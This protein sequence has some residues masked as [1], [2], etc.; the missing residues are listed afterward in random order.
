MT[1]HHKDDPEELVAVTFL[2]DITVSS[3]DEWILWARDRL[4]RVI[5]AN[6]SPRMSM[7]SP[8]LRQIT[9]I[10]H[11]NHVAYRCELKEEA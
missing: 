2:E 11:D 9:I 4:R 5:G 7:F 8:D 6:Y 3:K 10:D 1:N